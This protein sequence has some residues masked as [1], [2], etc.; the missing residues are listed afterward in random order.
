[1]SETKGLMEAPELEQNKQTG[2]TGPGWVPSSKELQE[3]LGRVKK[4]QQ[5]HSVFRSTVFTL[6]VVASVAV[7]VAT[8]WMPVM[9][10]YGVSMSPSLVD[11]N[12]VVSVKESHFKPGEVV[13]FYYNNKILVKRAIAEA[14][15]WVNIDETGNVYVNGRLLSEPY[16]SEKAFGDC[17]I[18]LPYQV[19]EGRIFVMGDNRAVSIDSRN[20]AVGCVA[21]EQ[22]VGKLKYLVWPLNSIGRIETDVMTYSDD[23]GGPNQG[24]PDV[25]PAS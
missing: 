24:E 25:V 19:P 11:G 14:G 4:R 1:M 2:N 9:R 10:I 3:E 12:I 7:L 5:F 20:T 18:E 6:V 16:I 23:S 13:A 22:I 15:D 21:E 17:N 8:L